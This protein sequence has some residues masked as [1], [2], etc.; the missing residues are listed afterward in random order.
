MGIADSTRWFRF[1]FWAGA[2][3]LVLATAS[4]VV[5]L[6]DWVGSG[7]APSLRYAVGPLLSL[8]TGT[9]L[10]IAARLYLRRLDRQRAASEEGGS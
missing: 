1:V 6:A 7:D 2:G 8:S 10:M 3:V 4:A 9:L 5:L